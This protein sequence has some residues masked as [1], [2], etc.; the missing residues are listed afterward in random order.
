MTK[1]LITG[2]NGQLG[3][4]LKDVL[5]KEEILLTD[6]DNMDITSPDQIEKIFSDFKPTH[7]VHGAA[8]T[9]VDGC[10]ENP[11]I[12]QKVNAEGTK[13]LAEACNKHKCQMIYVSTDYVFDGTKQEPYTEENKTNPQSVYGKTK[14]DGEKYTLE[15]PDS[16][17]VR[18]SWVYGE[19]KNFVRT[20]L[21]L[22]EKMDE[23][24]VVNDQFGRPTYAPDLAQAIYDII[25]KQPESGIYNV[26]GDGSI[27]SWADFAKE[28]FKIAGKKTKVVGISTDEYLSQY[29]D[30]KIAPRPSY[31][32]LG[33]SKTKNNDM[34]LE[35]WNSS[36]R[37]ELER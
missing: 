7:L 3:L 21:T 17:V 25:Q 6:T 14:L 12:A 11:D 5:A 33:L 36:L 20:M 15:L 13:N 10:E 32:F 4:A 35:L 1:I 9:N 16:Y 24:R 27:I 2:G 28:I 19:G 23:I 22:S 26:T 31:S 37:K 18:T 29:P 30:K 34:P 8:M